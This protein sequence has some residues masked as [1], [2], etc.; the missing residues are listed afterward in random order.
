MTDGHPQSGSTAHDT[1]TFI[2]R[3]AFWSLGFVLLEYVVLMAIAPF[4]S[5]KVVSNGQVKGISDLRP[6]N[7]VE[8]EILDGQKIFHQIS[9]LTYFTVPVSRAYDSAEVTV[10][11]QNPWEDQDLF[12][13]VRDQTDWHYQLKLFDAPTINNL[14]WSHV[15]EHPT[16]YQRNEM[17]GSVS[18]FLGMANDQT[19]IG[20]YNYDAGNFVNTKFG[21]DGYLAAT[22]QT[23]IDTPLRGKHVLYA[24]VQNEP[25]ELTVSKQD[26]NWHDGEDVATIDIFKDSDEVYRGTIGDDGITDGSRNVSPPQSITITNPGPGLPENGVYKIV[27]DCTGD[28]VI[29]SMR[30]NLHKLIVDGPIYPIQNHQSYP[31]LFP[32]TAATQLYTNSAYITA[33]TLHNEATQ[34]VMI[35]D[36]ALPVTETRQ[37]VATLSGTTDISTVTIPKSDLIVNGIPGFFAFRPDQY[38][39][40]FTHATYQISQP[41]ETSLVDYLIADYVPSQSDG[42]WKTSTITFDL[43]HAV[44][45][46]GKLDWMIRAPKIDELGRSV[47]I[48]NIQVLLKSKPIIAR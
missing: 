6:T 20:L 32:K 35:N 28:T 41:Q 1:V 33:L 39:M 34:S 23:Y 5:V 45:K 11:Y 37:L 40:P 43:S 24:Y 26:L 19:I 30:T 42:D 14:Q 36:I 15:G 12:L 7:R 18:D 21:L 44:I 16:L 2:S 31:F 17:Y 38:F 46:D 8:T 47:T 3:F 4:G 25:F 10:T 13:G 48:K 29:T 9:E 27:I 22:E